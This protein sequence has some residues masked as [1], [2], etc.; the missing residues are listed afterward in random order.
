MIPL[1][2]W[3]PFN[4]RYLL[5]I[6]VCCFR[7]S[8]SSRPY[9]LFLPTFGSVCPFILTLDFSRFCVLRP[10]LDRFC[11]LSSLFFFLLP[12][13]LSFSVSLW[14]GRCE[15]HGPS[16]GR[17][18]NRICSLRMQ[19][20]KKVGWRGWIDEGRGVGLHLMW[21][22]SKASQR[23]KADHGPTWCCV[24]LSTSRHLS[25]S[26]FLETPSSCCFFFPPQL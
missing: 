22:P 26:L 25:V 15:D 1:K 24:P 14:M 6:Q 13:P 17:G 18:E 2:W 23:I 9:S 8:E 10:P 7:L 3:P 12:L 5:F 20:G 16:R 11:L 19:R 21:G 4:I